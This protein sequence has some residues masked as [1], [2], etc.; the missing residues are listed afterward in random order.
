MSKL[1]DPEDIEVFVGGVEPDLAASV[2]T[3]RIIEEYKNR[4]DHALKLEEAKRILAALGITAQDYGI[5]DAKSLLEH[6]HGCVAE[7]LNRDSGGANG[8]GVDEEGLRV[9]SG[10]PREKKN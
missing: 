2:E 9:S 6:W 10:L 4:P 5:S 8:T 1:P 3:E 7:L